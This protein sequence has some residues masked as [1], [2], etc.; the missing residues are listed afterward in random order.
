MLFI[1]IKNFLWDNKYTI[2]LF[3]SLFLY[4]TDAFAASCTATGK[5][6]AL[7]CAGQEIF[8]GLRK[9]IYPAATIGVACVCIGG[10]FGSFNWKWLAAILIG[11]FVISYASGVADLAGGNGADLDG[12][13]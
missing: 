5:F 8:H 2:M 11:I 10:M 4:T 13:G 7:K 6:T 1:K 9:I 3:L 12:A